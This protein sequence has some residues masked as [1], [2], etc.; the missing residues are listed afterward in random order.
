MAKRMRLPNGFGRITKINNKNLRKPYR[1]MVT[2]GFGENGRPIGKILKPNGYF[3]TYNEAYA[4]L[5]EYHK[6]PIDLEAS[7]T[8]KE[9]FKEWS[10]RKYKELSQ[11]SIRSYDSAWSYCQRYKDYKV[12]DIRARHIRD[13]VENASKVDGENII[14]ATDTV[15]TNIKH[16]WNMM[17]DYAVEYEIVDK[18]WARTFDARIKLEHDSHIS[19]TQEEMEVLWKYK[20]DDTAAITLIQCYTGWRPSELL[21]IKL[22]DVDLEE[23]VMT[24]GMKTDAGKAR[25]IPIHSKIQELTKNKYAESLSRGSEYFISGRKGKPLSYSAYFDHF[26]DLMNRLGLNVKHR[27][28]DAR[29]HFVTIAKAA[30]VDEYAIKRIV[31]HAISDLTERV[32]TD[33]SIE[34][35]RTELEKIYQ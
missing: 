18:N 22:C 8:V 27:P 13:C 1:A 34:W 31:G 5:M 4:A 7:M 21:N 30:G 24:G 15:K 9:L 11:S 32:Y 2:I 16:L 10:T 28:H 6:N 14:E 26:T 35:L 17:L 3:R 19:F 20:Y 29:K 12:T 33:R 25:T 23:M